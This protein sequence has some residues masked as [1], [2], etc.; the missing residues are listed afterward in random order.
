ST[1]YHSVFAKD[2]VIAFLRR[3]D[4]SMI[5]IL[6][7]GTYAPFCLITLNGTLGWF[8]FILINGLAALGVTFKLTLFHSP[9]W[10]STSI[11]VGM[12][13]LIIFFINDLAASL[14]TGGMIF[15]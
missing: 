9:R 7:A 5:F 15:L 13:W 8:L 14:A 6:I 1:A 11:Y 12:G 10:L 3:I 2:K 4:H